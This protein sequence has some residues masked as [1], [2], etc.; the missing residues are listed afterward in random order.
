M[1]LPASVASASLT[2]QLVAALEG[3]RTAV[4]IRL[5]VYPGRPAT[6]RPPHAWIDARH[7]VINSIVAGSAMDHVANVELIVVHG[8][9]DSRDAITQRD[10][11]VDGFNTYLRNALRGEGL[12]GGN[13]VLERWRVDDI[14]N[15]TPDWVPERDRTTYY[16]TLYRLEVSLSD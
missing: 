5:N 6:I 10:A 2:S 12:A 11:W 1:T 15:Y 4:G 8:L 7:D 16:A 3:Y 13:S 14:P 9:F